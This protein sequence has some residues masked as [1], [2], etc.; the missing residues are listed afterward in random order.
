MPRKTAQ[1]DPALSIA[2]WNTGFYTYRDPL[3]AQFK[4]YGINLVQLHDALIDGANMEV[5]DKLRV[6][7]RPGF[8]IFCP[9]A[10]A[11]TEVVKD[12]NSFR[13]LNG[14]VIATF[15]STARLA[16]FDDTT[17]TTVFTKSTIEQGY[18]TSLGNLAYFSDGASGDLI[19]W[20]TTKPVSAINPSPWGLPAPT[21]AP[22]L[23]SPGCWLP[24]TV[25]EINNAILDPNGSVEVVTQVYGGA[26]VT[27]ATEPLWPTTT[28]STINDGS[29]Q[30]TNVGTLAIWLPA[31]FYPVPVVVL[32]T[33]GNLE[34]ATATSPA[35]AAWDSAT[36]YS[37]GET[38]SFAGQYWT[39]LVSNT[40]VPPSQNTTT[41]TTTGSTSTT[42]PTWVLAVNPSQTGIYPTAPYTP[43]WNKSVGGTTTDGNYTWKNIGPGTLVESFGTSYVY[44]YRTIY[45]AL[46]TASPVTL[47]TGSIFGPQ[48]STITSFAISDNIVT[49][50][51][52][53]NFIPG[54]SFSIQGVSVGTY[55]NNQ[56]FTVLTA[57]L[58]AT[59]FSAVFTHADVASTVDSG[60][61]LNLI[62]TLTGFGNTSPL[63]NAVVAITATS[64]TAG[65]VRVFAQNSFA[66]GIQ[67]TFANVTVASFLNG[68]QFEVDNVDPD[69]NWFE[70]FFSTSQGIA[71][72]DQAQT[73]DTGTATFNSIEIYR[74]SDGGGIYLFVGAVTNPMGTTIIPYDSGINTAGLG[75]DNGVPGTFVW[76]NPNHVTSSSL[77]ATAAVPTPSGGSGRFNLVQSA[78]ASNALQT[79]TAST[80]ATLGTPVT[81]NNTLLLFVTTFQLPT[82]TPSDNQGNTYTLILQETSPS[83]H[84][85]V[86]MSLYRAVSVAAGSTTVKVTGAVTGGSNF[87]Q[88]AVAECSGLNGTAGPNNGQ[89]LASGTTFNT[90]TITTTGPLQANSVVFSFGYFD[91]LTNSALPSTPPSGYTR[92]SNQVVSDPPDANSFQQSAVAYQAQTADGTFSPTWATPANS[93]RMGITA[94]FELAISAPSDG[95]NATQFGF[96]VPLGIA[97]TGIEIDLDA[98]FNGTPG[99]GTIEVQLLKAGTPVG[100]IITIS[101]TTTTT[102]YTL[103]GADNLWGETWVTS[104]FNTTSWGVQIT[105]TQQTGG[106]DATF[107]VRNVRARLTGSTSTTGWVF[108]DFVPDNNLDVLQI[109]P[110][111]HLGD[112]PPG[113]PGSTINTPVTA[114]AYWNG[115]IWMASGNFV[116]FTAGPDCEN[117]IP[118]QACPPAYRFQF[119]GPVVNL[120]PAPDGAAL[121]VYLTDRVRAIL[122]GPETI[123]FYPTDAFS[124]FGISN[125]NSV[126]RDGSMLGQFLTQGQYF[127]L[128]G[129]NKLEIGEHIADYLSANFEPALTYATMHRNGLDVGMFLSNGVDTVLR[130]GSNIGAWSVP[131]FPL[132]GA[133]ALRSI[134]TSVGT[135]SLMLASPNGGVSTATP[136]TTPE[137]GASAGTGTAWLNPSNITMGSPTDYATISL[138]GVASQTLQASHYPLNIPENAIIS[139]VRVSVTGTG[140]VAN[141]SL[142]NAGVGSDVAVPDGAVWNTPNNITL[143]NSS[144]PTTST[145]NAAGTPIAPNVVQ[146]KQAAFAYNSITNFPLAGWQSNHV[147]GNFGAQIMDSNGNVQQGTGTSGATV[148]TWNTMLG[149][150]TSDG[151]VTWTNQGPAPN[152]TMNVTA[153]NFLVLLVSNSAG[154]GISSGPTDNQSNTWT[155]Q[156]ENGNGNSR[157]SIYT[158]TA[159][160]T[161]ACTPSFV[162][163][164]TNQGAIACTFVEVEN[165]LSVDVTAVTGTGEVSGTPQTLSGGITTSGVNELILAQAGISSDNASTVTYTPSGTFSLVSSLSAEENEFA[166]YVTSIA[167]LTQTT[168]SAATYT[169][170]V[171]PSSNQPYRFVAI[172]LVGS[173]TGPSVS[174]QTDELVTSS[175]GFSVPSGSTILG[176]EASITGLQTVVSATTSITAQLS[177][178]G[179]VRTF[180]LTTSSGTQ[181]FGGAT[182]TWDL[183]LTP[184]EVN[185]SDF[186]LVI[187]AQDTNTGEAAEFELS[188]AQLKI[189]YAASLAIAPLNAVPGASTK[190]FALGTSNTTAVLGGPTDLW[191]MPWNS[192]FVVNNS[193]F[194]FGIFDPSLQTA[195]FAISEVQV[196]VFYQTPGNYLFVRD[197]NEWADNGSF[198]EANGTPYE[199]C[200]ATVGSIQLTQPGA[201]LFPLQHVV[202][203]FDAVGT[204]NNGGSSMPDI[205]ILPNEIAPTTMTPFILLPEAVQEPPE[206]QNNPSTSLLQLRWAVNMMNSNASQN[207]HHL[208]VKIQFEPENAPNTIK[209]ISFKESQEY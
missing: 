88:I 34:L 53:N 152:L 108:N 142:V 166:G 15:D 165:V 190:T 26:G 59:Q 31:S 140:Q 207:M 91:L 10:L 35:V 170:V 119:S 121:L 52:T 106:T 83:D 161:G 85:F 175:Y 74:L 11:D 80:S 203:Y 131:A 177:A 173:Q 155:Q 114:T 9:V 38:V 71:P 27:G 75:V 20:D 116:Y 73:A 49:F 67:V 194:G 132:C 197:L 78:Q 41:T 144:T 160:A 109:A 72:P 167:F 63:G 174:S 169:P 172:A 157:I 79:G 89:Y 112:P 82:V 7:R 66:P 127:E 65:I 105:A 84:G 145:V 159:S 42:Q 90:G 54:N 182:D 60:S 110:L 205:W 51:G 138:V 122:G 209:S 8:S 16:Q 137:L 200:Y 3:F 158:A 87:T 100:N 44:C 176:V 141:T 93:K 111:S 68:L 126:F 184:A 134:E 199:E 17:I 18:L 123:A 178:G 25:K 55:L 208:Q 13:N 24:F 103:G 124:N 204:L 19:R 198:G 133:G 36:T 192:P 30:W 188:A 180:N 150:T 1:V 179:T 94:S 14:D 2:F 156:V 128:L 86:V 45:G 97:V 143:N 40:D 101:P 147:Y 164:A 125:P 206:G 163:D 189:W 29:I 57:G 6:T 195:N 43:N 50:Q 148:P 70:V 46:S 139:G 115:R 171:T 99:F 153:G 185:A 92:F 187:Q 191:G 102:P 95:L 48:V 151:S 196:Q 39:A 118:E 37:V 136:L 4:S 193:A 47:N 96:A 107:E 202:G 76:S 201:P 5:T 33:N 186:G 69:G 21:I 23:S 129:E 113:A 117:G 28:S 98:F 58:S 32:D 56:S 154:S 120:I 162:T 64:V 62:A 130:Y 183:L 22:T 168:T 135:F 61:T 146:S 181:T 104:D 149:G 77:Y 12:F 81:G